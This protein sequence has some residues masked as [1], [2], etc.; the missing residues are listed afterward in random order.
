MSTTYQD[1]QDRIIA[2]LTLDGWSN[3]YP[4]PDPSFLANYGISEFVQETNYNQE[5]AIIQT[6]AGQAQYAMISDLPNFPPGNPLG[7]RKWLS[8]ND[9][10]LYNILPGTPGQGQYIFQT[11]REKLRETDVQ[12]LD[13]PPS[14]PLCWYLANDQVIGLYPAPV[15]SGILIQF[16]GNRDLPPLVNDTDTLPWMDRY[17]EACCL[18]GTVYYAKLQARGEGLQTLARYIAEAMDLAAKFNQAFAAKQ[19]ALINRRVARPY[20][21]YMDA[22]NSA[23]WYGPVNSGGPFPGQS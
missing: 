23:F 14:T 8:W 9:D 15:T 11:T 17:T 6:V 4:L 20:P 3:G 1:M 19:S 13:L 16:S 10:A 12:Y 5:S 2:L 18:F 21:D 7:P 22:G